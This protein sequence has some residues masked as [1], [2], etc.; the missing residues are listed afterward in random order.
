MKDCSFKDCS[1]VGALEIH[2]HDSLFS[3]CPEHLIWG[4]RYIWTINETFKKFPIPV[5][6]EI[7]ENWLDTEA[8]E[9][10]EKILGKEEEKFL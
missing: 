7:L 4:V 3:F 2:T 9:K 6:T 8:R 10:R 1:N 5:D